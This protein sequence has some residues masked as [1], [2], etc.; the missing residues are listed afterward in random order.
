MVDFLIIRNN[1]DTATSY[2]N[3]IGDGPMTYKGVTYS[4]LKDFLEKK[5]FSVTDLSDSDASPENVEE[6]LKYGNMKTIKAIIALDHGSC[7]AFY[8]EKNNATE[9]VITK[10]NAEELT[11]ELH[12]YTLACSTNGDNCVGQTA[13]E[14][15]CFSWLG[16]IEPVY[17]MKSLAFKECIWSYIEAMADGKTM[18]ECEDALRKAYDDRKSLSFVFGYNLDRLLLRKSHNNMTI[19]SNNRKAKWQYNM[20]IDGLWAYGPQIRNAWV[21]VK[22]LGWRKLWP[23]YDSQVSA[24]MTMAAHA[25]ADDRF[26]NFFEED[27]KIKEMY[28][29]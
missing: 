20:K 4:S 11:K 26:V 21:H 13:I 25:K 2:T 22:D 15:G 29:W 10:T 16:Y 1:C 28:V 19:N 17:A 18:E 23:D 12:V 14:K 27:D 8:G 9:P 7:S 3:W 6:W 5:G 24:L